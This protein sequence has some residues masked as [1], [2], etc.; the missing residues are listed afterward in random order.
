MARSDDTNDH[1]RLRASAAAAAEPPA[2][3]PNETLRRAVCPRTRRRPHYTPHAPQ[4]CIGR[5]RFARPRPPPD[6]VAAPISLRNLSDYQ[7]EREVPAATPP[8]PMSP[9]PGVSARATALGAR[10]V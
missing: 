5:Q 8:L 10:C 6:G 1:A 2:P 3:P 9:S 7:G 4:F